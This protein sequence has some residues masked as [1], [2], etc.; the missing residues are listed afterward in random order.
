M[1]SSISPVL[2]LALVTSALA[3]IATLSVRS[4][5]AEESAAPTTAPTTDPMTN[6]TTDPT[7]A[8]TTQSIYKVASYGIGHNIGM[9]MKSA[10]IGIDTDELK[11]GLSD[12]LEGKPSQVSE[13]Q[14]Q[15]AMAQVEREV[16]SKQAAVQQDLASTTK[17]AGAKFAEENAKLPG[18]TTTASGLQIQTIT[19]GTG[20]NPK[21]TDVVKVHYTGTLIDGT[22]FDSSVDR[23]EP[24][25]FA[26]NEVI[27]GWTEG[28]QLIKVGGKARL[29]IPS[30]LAYGDNPR[31]G[32]PIPPG[33]TLVFEVELL[34]IETPAK[35]D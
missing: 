16:M 23:G 14:L 15:A 2:S 25:S 18:V 22:K 32:G 29:V 33:S 19:E 12:A 11:R 30:D 8:P 20:P 4:S 26:L 7:T 27:P 1:K 34:G 10:P 35:A 21:A 6:P 17:I 28:V 24:I 31:P 5:H 9:Q 3:A 13:E